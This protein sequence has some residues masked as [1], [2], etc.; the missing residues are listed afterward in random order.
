ME[1]GYKDKGIKESSD[2]SWYLQLVMTDPDYAGQ[3]ECINEST[4]VFVD[5]CNRHDVTSS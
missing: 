2:A 5:Y 1:K 3:G 4:N